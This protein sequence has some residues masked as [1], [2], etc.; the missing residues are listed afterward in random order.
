ME[1]TVSEQKAFEVRP[2][3]TAEQ[4]RERAWDQ[5]MA[6]FGTFSRLLHRPKGDE[7][8][9]ASAQKRFDPVWHVIAHK[10][11]VFHRS[12]EYRV[13]VADAAIRRITIE[14]TDYPVSAA[15]PPYFNVRGMEHCEED[16]R[17]ETLVDGVKGV[18]LQA[19]ALA[20]A[21]RDEI[22]ELSGFA[23]ADAVVVPPQVRA[24]TIVQ[25]VVQKLM[26][27]Y[28]AD[29]IE[30]EGIEIEQ[31]NL[32]YR[33]VYVFQYVWEAKGKQAVV[34]L[35]AVGGEAR[36]GDSNFQQQIRQLGQ[37]FKPD[38]LFDLGA[39]TLGSLVPGGTIVLKLG[40]K[41]ARVIGDHQRRQ[42]KES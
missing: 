38:T 19:P 1:I 10:R 36:T 11:L 40:G 30:E 8:K 22:L 9:V 27:T 25:R 21:A 26:T 23:P 24:S 34:E 39:E 6:A 20:R 12:R 31:L 2:A 14:G 4:A 28:E 16:L 17:T 7:I 41:V 35:D 37:I 3:L 33:P 13:P 5:K 18:E 29:Q 42:Q 32:L 15:A